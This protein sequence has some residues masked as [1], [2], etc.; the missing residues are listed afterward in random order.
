MPQLIRP[1]EALGFLNEHDLVNTHVPI[2]MA[3]T[4]ETTI[5][6]VL[7]DAASR[8][9]RGEDPNWPEVLRTLGVV[10]PGS[11]GHTFVCP[12]PASPAELSELSRTAV[13]MQPYA[14]LDGLVDAVVKQ[15][16]VHLEISALAAEVFDSYERGSHWL[17][18]S[19]RALDG[20]VPV[21]L[22]NEEDGYGRVKR[23]LLRIDDGAFS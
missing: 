6:A 15:L 5:Q 8:S 3:V 18:Q 21:D 1:H 20:E 2:R 4:M 17:N 22:L 12:V 9:H 11:T 13:D 16:A 7:E 10:L 19:N 14:R 23:L